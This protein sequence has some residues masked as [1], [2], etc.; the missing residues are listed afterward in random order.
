M[1]NNKISEQT[2]AEAEYEYDCEWDDQSGD[3]EELGDI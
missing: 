1:F 2:E 3:D